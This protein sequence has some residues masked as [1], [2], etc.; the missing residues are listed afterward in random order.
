MAIFWQIVA[1][2][3]TAA[4][5]SGPRFFGLRKRA[6]RS[7]ESA[8]LSLIVATRFLRGNRKSTLPDNALST[9]LPRAFLG[10]VHTSGRQL[11]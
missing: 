3:I 8:E 4:H 1:R 2:E 6:G 9:G 7:A 11:G 10:T 5:W